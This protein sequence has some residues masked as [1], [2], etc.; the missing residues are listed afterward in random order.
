MKY[1]IGL[2]IDRELFNKIERLQGGE[3]RV[4]KKN[5]FIFGFAIGFLPDDEKALA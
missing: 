4:P 5:I 2:T 3:K 1:Y